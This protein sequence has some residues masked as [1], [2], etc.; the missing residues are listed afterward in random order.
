MKIKL[1][2]V[3]QSQGQH[4]QCSTDQKLTLNDVTQH[5]TDNTTERFGLKKTSQNMLPH[6]IYDSGGCDDCDDTECECVSVLSGLVIIIST[7]L[8]NI[9]KRRISHGQN[10]T[11]WGLSCYQD[12]SIQTLPLDEL[13]CK[14]FVHFEWRKIAIKTSRVN[15]TPIFVKEC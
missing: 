7:R 4:R 1:D 5:G 14:I 8:P 10:T 11:M 13:N 2:Q 3:K 6:A 12:L 15:V 9:R